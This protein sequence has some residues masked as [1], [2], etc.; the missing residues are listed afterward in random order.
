MLPFAVYYYS[1]QLL[2][3][4][5]REENRLDGSLRQGRPIKLVLVDDYCDICEGNGIG[6]QGGYTYRLRPI[7]V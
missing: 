3:C 4:L 5:V 6:S 7:I 1:L 2:D